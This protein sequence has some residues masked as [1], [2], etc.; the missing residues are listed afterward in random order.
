MMDGTNTGAMTPA[1]L[2]RAELSLRDPFADFTPDPS[3]VDM[4]GWN[5]NHQYFDATLNAVQPKIIVELGVWK[6]MS[7]L[8]MAACN[9][10]AG[11]DCAIL[12][13][14]TWLGSSAHIAEPSRRTELCEKSGY[15]TLYETFLNNVFSAGHQ[16]VITPLPLDGASAASGLARTG[17]KADVIHIDASHEYL[18]ALTD[19]RAFWPILAD[20]GVLIV[21]DYAGWIG[22]TRAANEFAAEVNRP[23]FASNAKAVIPKDP[24]MVAET[25]IR[26]F[27]RLRR[28][29]ESDL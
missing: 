15:P 11:R 12:A 26:R 17:F 2:L 24:N 7:S 18:A 9:K 28:T 20:D 19:F 25:R 8:H 16:D 23:I 22:V 10:A 21:D 29:F 6:G 1:A 4:Q 14:D 3:R 13:I 5:S 27:R